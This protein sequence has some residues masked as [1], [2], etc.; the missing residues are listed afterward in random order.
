LSKENASRRSKRKMREGTFP[1]KES[2]HKREKDKSNAFSWKLLAQRPCTKNAF[3]RK[4]LIQE[5]AHT[6]EKERPEEKDYRRN[7]LKY[8][9]RGRETARRREAATASERESQI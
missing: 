3:S 7:S 9:K 5:S 1:S 8:R 2:E 4:L 6:E